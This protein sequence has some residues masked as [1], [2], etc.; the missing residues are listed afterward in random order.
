MANLNTTGRMIRFFPSSISVIKLTRLYCHIDGL[1]L[2]RRSKHSYINYTSTV[3]RINRKAPVRSRL[4]WTVYKERT[5][6]E[7]HEY[8]SFKGLHLDEFK[9]RFELEQNPVATIKNLYSLP[10][11]FPLAI[12]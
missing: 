11:R 2:G 12:H 5:F 7:I 4:C 6:K 8:M 1:K 10:S 9:G 3:L